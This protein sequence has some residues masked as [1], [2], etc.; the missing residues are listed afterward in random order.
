MYTRKHCNL[1]V[2]D[3]L[4][5]GLKKTPREMNWTIITN[6][7]AL[8]EKS[9]HGGEK[10]FAPPQSRPFKDLAPPLFIYLFHRAQVSPQPFKLLAHFENGTHAIILCHFQASVGDCF[11]PG[12]GLGLQ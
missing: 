5:R 2:A 12:L 4:E 7:K 11:G 6:Q 8:V 3:D 10:N 9:S 1:Q